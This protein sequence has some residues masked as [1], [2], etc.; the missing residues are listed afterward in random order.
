MDFKNLKY[1]IVGSGFFGSVV[2]ERIANVLEEQV[3]VVEKRDHVGGNSYSLED[4]ETGILYHRYGTHIFHTN[5][6]IVW[7][8][9]NQFTSFNGYFHQVL[10]TFK[11]KVYQMPINLETINS[12]YSKNLK[13]YEVDEFLKSEIL[14]EFY[15]EPKNFE[16]KAIS[17]I[18]RPLYE[19]FIKSYTKK[20]WQ[21]EPRNLPEFILTRLPFRSNYNESY[22]K[23][24]WQGIPLDGYS[25]IFKKLLSSSNIKVLLDTDFFD[26]KDRLDKDTLVIFSGPIDRFFEYRFGKLDYRTLRFEIEIKPYKDYQGTSVMNFAEEAIPYTRIHEPRHLHPERE[27]FYPKNKTLI[28]KEFSLKDDG[29]NPYYPVN[30]KSNTDRY[31]QY[32]ALSEKSSNLIIGGRLGDYQYYDMHQSIE[33]ALLLFEEIRKRYTNDK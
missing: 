25:V 5:N 10:T 24:Q 27:E 14:K 8:Y 2:A 9:I 11:D 6:K 18:G 4:N 26:I 31:L 17:L 32:R 23:S 15:P 7:D 28:I 29:E 3:L 22:Y 1:L 19:A 16:E 30:N 20:Q 12:F 33:K 21:T 13:P